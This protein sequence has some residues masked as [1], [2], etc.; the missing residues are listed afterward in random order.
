MCI[1]DRYSV[2]ELPEGIRKGRPISSMDIGSIEVSGDGSVRPMNYARDWTNHPDY[3]K[4]PYSMEGSWYKI[5]QNL[6]DL[7]ISFPQPESSGADRN[8][9]VLHSGVRVLI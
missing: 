3:S 7:K 6:T 9:V 1:R 2:D 8:G 4:D 5:V